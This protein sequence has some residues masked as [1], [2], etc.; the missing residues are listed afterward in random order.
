[1]EHQNDYS[2]QTIATIEKDFF[3]DDLLKSLLNS[4]MAIE[5]VKELRELLAK[6]GCKL[7]KWSS[8]SREVLE[9]IPAN[10]IV[11]SVRN[12]KEEALPVQ[13]ALGVQICSEDDT[14]KF[15][16]KNL[17]GMKINT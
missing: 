14:F 9:T 5:L 15:S 4:Q 16:I 7:T 11:E 1:M 8:N 12:F 17:V 13:R 10:E 2:S 6:A 3:V